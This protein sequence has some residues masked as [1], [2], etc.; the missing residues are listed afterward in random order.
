[1]RLLLAFAVMAGAAFAAVH[2]HLKEVNTV[3]LLP[4][5]NSL[6]QY[7]ATTLTEQGVLQVVT[8]P[9]KADAILTDKIGEAFEQKMNELFPPPKA[10][11]ETSEAASS[12]S[13]DDAWAQP[14]QRLGSF[15]RG[16][17][18]LFLVDRQTGNVLWSTYQPVRSSRPEDV[19]RRANEIT[20]RLKK[21]R[22]AK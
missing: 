18:T 12:Q 21:D 20:H 2:P 3:Y 10:K 15:S 6:D 13:N 17:G 7:L 11:E 5:S 16:R 22:K 4:M 1:M 9:H 19:S 14:A 8:D